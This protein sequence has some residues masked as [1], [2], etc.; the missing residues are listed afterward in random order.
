[1]TSPAVASTATAQ[2]DATAA[3]EALIADV[4]LSRTG[5]ASD[6]AAGFAARADALRPELHA[7]GL[8]EFLAE[9]LDD[10]PVPFTSSLL[11][12]DGDETQRRA[13]YLAWV[14][15]ADSGLDELWAWLMERRRLHGHDWWLQGMALRPDAASELM[16]L[17]AEEV[18]RPLGE[19]AARWAS[20]AGLADGT[21]EHN[22]RWLLLG[23]GVQAGLP[24]VNRLLSSLIDELRALDLLPAE[25]RVQVLRKPNTPSM[26]MPVR[27]PGHSLLSIPT[28]LTPSTVQYLQHELAHLAEHAA[29]PTGQTLRDRW[30]FD[31]VRSEGW[32]LLLEY[33]VRSPDWLVR[34]GFDP[35]SARTVSRFLEEEEWF[36]RGMMSLDLTLARRLMLVDTVAA[37]RAE[38]VAL[39]AE[40]GIEWA[41]QLMLFRSLRI[42]HWS[43]YSAGWAWRDSAIGLLQDRHGP[44]WTTSPA[45]WKLLAGML[46]AA[47]SASSALEYLDQ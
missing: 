31:P 44:G 27:L 7:V 28:A 13:S 37:A 9:L 38:A 36:S 10:S 41:P 33:A 45:A 24:P 1:V 8:S 4:Q 17:S 40:A 25:H 39:A 23:N 26:V 47:Q 15:D 34:V 19:C 12:L 30:R 11:D 3:V 2:V 21:A 46:A 32:A 18:P 22:W 16:L 14:Q 43:S 6:T 5:L 20:E 29:R 35:I 42:L